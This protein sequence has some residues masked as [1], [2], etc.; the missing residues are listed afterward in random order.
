M[1]AGAGG[2]VV[3]SMRRYW[4]GWTDEAF[5]TAAKG[6]FGEGRTM[7]EVMEAEQAKRRV[8]WRER[9]RLERKSWRKGDA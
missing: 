6:V 5:P 2:S 1:Q 7:A 3:I 8:S 4:T 9:Q